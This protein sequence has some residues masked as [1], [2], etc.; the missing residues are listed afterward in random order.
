[1]LDTGCLV[2]DIVQFLVSARGATKQSLGQIDIEHG[3][4]SGAARRADPREAGGRRRTVRVMWPYYYFQPFVLL[5]IYECA[6]SPR[7]RAS[8]W[9]WPVLSVGFLV[10]ATTIAPYVGLMS[11]GSLGR[12][13]TG[14]LQSGVMLLICARDMAPSTRS[15]IAR[16]CS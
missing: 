3:A 11:V 10:V 12:V 13:V 15:G 4:Q 7:H 6:T 9:R 5:V 2:T 1:M 16:L 14:I 8:P